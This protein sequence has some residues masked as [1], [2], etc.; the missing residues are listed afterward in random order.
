MLLARHGG[1][2]TKDIRRQ[3]ADHAVRSYL[4]DECNA[5]Q[6]RAMADQ[7]GVGILREIVTLTEAML[8]A[9]ERSPVE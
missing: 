6:L 7:F 3:H 8:V 2:A 4:A 1:S 9:W 5:Q